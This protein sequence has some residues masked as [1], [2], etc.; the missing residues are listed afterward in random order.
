[1][2]A[3]ADNTIKTVRG[4]ITMEALNPKSLIEQFWPSAAEQLKDPKN[5][6]SN[7]NPLVLG[8]I[9]VGLVGATVA[10]ISFLVVKMKANPAGLVS[11][12]I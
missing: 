1:M 11:K 5:F 2:P 9:G 3:T 8:A 12:N 4:I 7:L 6:V 10:A